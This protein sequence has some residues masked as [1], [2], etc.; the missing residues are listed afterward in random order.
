MDTGNCESPPCDPATDTCCDVE[1]NPCTACDDGVHCDM[2]DCVGGKYD[3]N[4]GLCWEDQPSGTRMTFGEAGTYC[5]SLDGYW[6]LPNISELRSLFRSGSDEE[7][8]VLEGDMEWTTVP[9]G[10]CRVWDDCLVSSCTIGGK[11]N[12]SACGTKEGPGAGGCYWDAA[13]SGECWTYW[14]ASEAA[15]YTDSAWAVVFQFGIVGRSSKSN[16]SDVRCV[17]SGP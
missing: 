15:D 7:C 9:N 11:C 2:T 5:S 17:R 14:S 3:P 8:N 6:H 4:S 10:Y 16:R 12:P 1:G 13:L